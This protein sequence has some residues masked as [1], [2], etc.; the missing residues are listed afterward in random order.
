ML[1]LWCL[2]TLIVPNYVQDIFLYLG[3]S[4]LL[5][6]NILVFLEMFKSASMP[7]VFFYIKKALFR[8][9]V[10]LMWCQIITVTILQCEE[11]DQN[12]MLLALPS[13]F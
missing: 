10:Q 2:H 9:Y 13:I 12:I 4:I 6:V 1:P 8:P 5:F 7:V 11:Q 3:S